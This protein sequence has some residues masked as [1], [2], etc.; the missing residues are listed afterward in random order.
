[1]EQSAHWSY[2]GEYVI[3]FSVCMMS[4]ILNILLVFRENIFPGFIL[5][6][7]YF[8]DSVLAPLQMDQSTDL[9][10]R[11][12]AVLWSAHSLHSSREAFSLHRIM[13][14]PLKANSSPEGFF[15]THAKNT[16]GLSLSVN[17][18]DMLSYAVV[19][20]SL[21][22]AEKLYKSDLTGNHF[23]NYSAWQW[24]HINS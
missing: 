10:G 17:A 22:S 24:R 5:Q 1:M 23:I 4:C 8:R 11:Y 9:S 15:V 6:P 3:L 12:H 2:V 18:P 21:D 20:H 14:C 13:C 16:S 7:S 19:K